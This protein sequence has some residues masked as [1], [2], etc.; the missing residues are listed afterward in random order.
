[1]VKGRAMKTRQSDRQFVIQVFP[2]G[3]WK[4]IAGGG[5]LLLVGFLSILYRAEIGYLLIAFGTLGLGWGSFRLYDNIRTANTRHR[6][7]AA[8]ADAL[9]L[10]ATAYVEDTRRAG[11]F[12]IQSKGVTYYPP[13]A[14]EREAMLLSPGNEEVEP[15]KPDLLR[16]LTQPGTVYVL[17][18]A[19][20]SGKSW[21]AGHVADYWLSLGIVPAVFGTKTDNPGY[22][23]NGCDCL[24]TDDRGEM[25]KALGSIVAQCRERQQLLKA[26]RK[27]QPIILDD[28]IATLG[29]TEK[30]GYQFMLLAATKLASSG[31]IAYFIMQGDTAAAF[32]LKELGAMLKNNFMQLNITP[33]PAADGRVIPGQ[34]RGEL[35]YPN[36][37]PKNAVA[38]DLLPGRPGCFPDPAGLVIEGDVIRVERSPK[39][40]IRAALADNPDLGIG[41]LQEAGWG[42]KGGS[43]HQ[44][45]RKIIERIRQETTVS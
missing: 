4:I 9:K 13:T 23:W 2:H 28:W 27:P 31:I 5:F 42:S 18:G 21:Q 44:E 38:V 11:A 37:S 19:Q 6:M 22:D 34:S 43:K 20:R 10:R 15:Q 45:R 32:G 36:T 14:P 3:G 26:E 40:K 7:L 24:I 16:V 12:V 8:E 17:A 41:K 39:D 35:V 25:D 33:I 29:L 1:M 30:I